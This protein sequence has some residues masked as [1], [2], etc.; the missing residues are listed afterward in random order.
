MEINSNMK[1]EEFS[2]TELIRDD[3]FIQWVKS[4]DAESN[5]YWSEMIT[6]FPEKKKVIEMAKEYV[7][8]IAADTGR[9]I[10][11]NE[12]SE[13][14][15]ESVK[16]KVA[17]F[18]YTDSIVEED[19]PKFRIS[20]FKRL[21][22]A[23][24]VVVII[25]LGYFMY[26]EEAKSISKTTSKI[27][28]SSTS[29]EVIKNKDDL[30]QTVMLS[31]GSTVILHPGSEIVFE[32][33]ADKDNRRI[34]LTG[35]A[36]FEV[37][38]NPEIPFMVYTKGIVTRVLGTSFEINAPEKG[39]EISV[40]V[41]TGKVSVYK[42]TEYLG[43][44]TGESSEVIL[45][46]NQSMAFDASGKN[47][48]YKPI[49]KDMKGQNDIDEHLFIFDEAPVSVIFD[50]LESHYGV[51]I[52]YNYNTMGSCPLTATLT[53]YPLKK[54]M[55]IICSALMAEFRVTGNQIFVTGKGCR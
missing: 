44:H 15:W 13:K 42:A 24:S 3:E 28:L 35:K 18:T 11:T 52:N 39:T 6:R 2:L 30:P 48:V 34:D 31:D 4:P 41:S 54:K 25:A 40:A 33:F 1:H 32:D 50:A 37:S 20:H 43:E 7:L 53:G 51:T 16:E 29:T 10:P 27:A 45:E 26:S 21:M 22:V 47:L 12:R 49:T 38:K 14:M 8:L 36:F 55:E 19:I 46:K 9:H 5:A 23:A 17:E